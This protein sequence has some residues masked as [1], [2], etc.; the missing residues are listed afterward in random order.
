MSPEH[1]KICL[2]KLGFLRNAARGDGE[3][4]CRDVSIEPI[5][6]PTFKPQ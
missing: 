1:L 3:D 4:A 2:P 5:S 6:V